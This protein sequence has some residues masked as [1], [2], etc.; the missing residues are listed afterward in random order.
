MDRPANVGLDPYA[1]SKIQLARDALT[2]KTR[3]FAR[4]SIAR[5]TERGYRSDWTDFLEF[6]DQHGR[7]ALPADP[8]TVALYYT[9]LAEAG[10]KPSTIKRREGSGKSGHTRA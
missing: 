7:Q 1:T 4:R 8:E 6:C 5:T 2:A 10:A 9:A 3:E